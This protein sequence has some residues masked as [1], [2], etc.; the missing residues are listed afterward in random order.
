MLRQ[1]LGYAIRLKML[2][3]NPASAVKNPMPRPGEIQPFESWEE[4][5]SVAVE[6]GEWGAIPMVAAG[7]GLRPE[8]WIAL[9]WRDLDLRARSLTVQRA[10]SKGTLTRWG[11][12]QRSRRR[13]PLRQ[14]VIDTLE[15]VERGGQLVFPG[16]RGGYLDLHNW[17]AREWKPA[18]E[19]AGL[20][21]RRIY[22]LR[23]TYATWSLA[24]GVG[25]FF[26]L[27]RR[28]GTSVEMIDRTYGHLA[29]D[30]DAYEADLLDDW[31]RQTAWMGAEWARTQRMRREKDRRFAGKPSDG[32]EPSTP[33]L[34]CGLG[35]VAVGCRRL[36]IGLFEPFSRL[37]HLR[38]VATGC[39]R[40]AP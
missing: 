21:K 13:V 5:E 16:S 23:H 30:A 37:A 25:R 14:R 39:A 19:A 31:D 35:T 1:V 12:T 10:F 40:L 11:K 6:L 20:P 3:E 29:P 32:L 24:A 27:A 4:I 26:T 18:L 36:P 15:T 34:P 38:P 33:S 8:E 22:D 9:E 7:T 2:E 17:R 28:M